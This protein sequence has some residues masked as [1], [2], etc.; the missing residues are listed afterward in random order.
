M[1]NKLFLFPRVDVPDLVPL[2][3][4]K[5][6]A[7]GL[8]LSSTSA[9]APDIASSSNAIDARRAVVTVAVDDVEA[10]ESAEYE[11]ERDELGGDEG[12]EGAVPGVR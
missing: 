10:L 5:P 6:T 12:I 4:P 9:S 2:P 3:L 8:A 1:G 7:L 11:V